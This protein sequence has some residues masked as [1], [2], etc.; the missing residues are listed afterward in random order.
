MPPIAYPVEPPPGLLRVSNGPITG[1]ADDCGG[2]CATSRE[3][4]LLAP[5]SSEVAYGR[6]SMLHRPQNTPQVPKTFG[7][8]GGGAAE[9]EEET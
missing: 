2:T 9:R 5:P 7:V 8:L 4:S 6:S 3:A 1:G